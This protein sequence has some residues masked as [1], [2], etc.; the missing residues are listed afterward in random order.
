MLKIQA[1][2]G[3]AALVD[4]EL[5]AS[6]VGCKPELIFAGL[7]AAFGL[8]FALELPPCT[9]ADENTHFLRTYSVSRGHLTPRLMFHGYG[10]DR[11]PDS[12]YNI[13]MIA[14]RLWGRPDQKVTSDDFRS[15]RAA[16]D[17]AAT[18]RSASFGGAAMYTFVPY[19]PQAAG[20]LLARAA[21]LN[22]LLV[23]Y[24]GR[25]ANLLF[26]VVL[27]YFAVRITPIFKCV[28]GALVLSPISVQQYASYSPDATV[29][30]VSLLL[31]AV[32]LRVALGSGPPARG[33]VLAGIVGLTAWLTVS[34]FPYAAVI[35]LF[36]AI[37]AARIG[38]RRRYVLL[39]LGLAALVVG[40]MVFT[41]RA[42]RGLA[43]DS[44]LVS[45]YRSSIP[46]QMAYIKTHPLKYVKVC[47]KTCVEHSYQWIHHLTTL[48]AL[49]TGLAPLY[50]HLFL[51]FLAAVAVLD[52][53]F[54]IVLSRRM[55]LAAVAA[56]VLSMGLM[57][58][59]QYAWHCAGRRSRR[60]GHAGPLLPPHPA[61]VRDPPE[62]PILQGLG[63]R[64]MA[65]GGHGRGERRHPD[66]L[67]R[68][69]HP[70]ILPRG[71]GGDPVADEHDGP[72]CDRLGRR[73]EGTRSEERRWGS[74][75]TF[76]RH[77]VASRRPPD[78][79]SEWM[80][81]SCTIVL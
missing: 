40:L 81:T 18:F 13:P 7:L 6:G 76:R 52:Q 32:L 78:G 72:G 59:A 36:A 30:G 79:A 66:N 33:H 35:A 12:V 74:Q 4:V 25:L 14:V 22:P 11:F 58:T 24:A 50:I 45:G 8:V 19:I 49:D 77:V 5:D 70:A 55:K 9:V 42:S 80:K 69:D 56:G 51:L 20:V 71:C 17:S 53:P 10:G 3:D 57:F 15:M 34:K 61:D 39:G 2:P 27:V 64:P 75:R 23:F 47:V 29:N 60:R 21:H 41:T 62:F 16:S 46:G 37:P 48:G 28:L 68:K 26:A 54:A 31:V 44:H 1:E 43:P 65:P 38:S 73:R 67:G 63:R